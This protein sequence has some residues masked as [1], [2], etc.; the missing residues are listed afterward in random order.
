M[1]VYMYALF[2]TPDDFSTTIFITAYYNITL[3]VHPFV[4]PK[5]EPDKVRHTTKFQAHT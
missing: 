1:G 5:N 3:E 4:S 2:D